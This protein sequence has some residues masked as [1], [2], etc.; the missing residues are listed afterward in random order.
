MGGHAR[1]RVCLSIARIAKA[2]RLSN[3]KWKSRHESRIRA[4][5]RRG[6]LEEGCELRCS[7]EE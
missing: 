4:S 2:G 5:E 7:R 1:V 6:L 3:A